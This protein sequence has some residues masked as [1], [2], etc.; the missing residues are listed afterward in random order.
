MG[1]RIQEQNRRLT[2]SLKDELDGLLSKIEQMNLSIAQTW[3]DLEELN[4]QNLQFYSSE[5]KI[6]FNQVKFL[7]HTIV[8]SIRRFV[9]YTSNYANQ[10]LVDFFPDFIK[11][12]IGLNLSKV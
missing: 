10:T 8:D 7:L 9:S 3:L 1:K 6:L 11:Q 12:K 4:A 5:L 2:G